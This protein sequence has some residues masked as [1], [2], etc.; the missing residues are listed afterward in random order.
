MKILIVDDS[1]AV[2]AYVKSMF[3]GK[4]YELDHVYNG[5]E[6]VE[7]FKASQTADLVLLDWEM[8]EMDGPTALVEMRKM[9]SSP[10]IMVTSKNDIA[11]IAHVLENG[12]NEYIMKPFTQDILFAKISDVIGREVA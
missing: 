10:I 8:P 12:A 4:N 3:A 7:Y 1:K 2:H 6:A 11:D 9:T 5:K